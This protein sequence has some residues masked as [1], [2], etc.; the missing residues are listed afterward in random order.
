MPATTANASRNSTAPRVF[1]TTH[2]T[3][4]LAAG[5]ADCPK[6]Q[7][8]LS[9][10][11]RAYWYPVY[12]FVRRCG[13]DAHTAQDHTQEFFARLIEK[14]A[15][16]RI[17]PEKGRFR[18]FLLASVKNFLSNEREHRDAVKRGGR[19]TFVSWDE[20]TAEA[21]YTSEPADCMSP[22]RIFERRWA[23]VV[24]DAVHRKIRE[25]YAAAHKAHLFDAIQCY[26]SPVEAVCYSALAT[27]LGMTEGAVRVCVHRLRQH[28]GQTLRSEIANTVTDPADIED[29]LRHLFSAAAS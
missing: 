27:Q 22:D 11:C 24:I 10:L 4:V 23:M 5:G 9:K 29:E 6:A 26:L 1:V 17:H 2:W 15:L 12:A 8:A 25:D 28:F 18:S 7:E 20:Q 21:R 19:F 13:V 3:L 14:N 16:E